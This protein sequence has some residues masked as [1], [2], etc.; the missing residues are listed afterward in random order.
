MQKIQFSCS[1]FFLNTG[2]HSVFGNLKFFFF[3]ILPHYPPSWLF[4]FSQWVA[5]QDWMNLVTEILVLIVTLNTL[6]YMQYKIQIFQIR[7][8]YIQIFQNRMLHI[9][10]FQYR[11]IHIQMFHNRMFHIQMFQNRMLH[12]HISFFKNISIAVSSY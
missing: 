1:V 4:S 8:L 6:S 7:M 12:F 10:M 5:L 3:A 9:K 2:P 11:M